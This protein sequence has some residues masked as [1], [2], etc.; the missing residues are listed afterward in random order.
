[1][2]PRRREAV[3]K[4]AGL[5]WIDG[6]DLEPAIEERLDDGAVRNLNR[7]MDIFRPAAACSYEPA[8]HLC[9]PLAAV[10][11]GSFAK[12]LAAGIGK[13]DVMLLGSP[14][15]A[16]KPFWRFVHFLSPPVAASH[17]RHRPVPVL[18][19]EGAVFPLGLMSWP[20]CRGAV[21]QQALT[22]E[23]AAQG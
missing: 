8:A 18:A 17:P 23:K 4:A 5:L 13:P 16:R 9:E 2:A 7:N 1:L 12:P 20:P 15:G 19:L 11:E 6:V 21:P 22:G 14:A 10:F 3:A